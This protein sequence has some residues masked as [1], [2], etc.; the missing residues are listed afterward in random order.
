MKVKFSKKFRKQYEKLDVKIRA[1]FESRLQMFMKDLFD[2]Q[3]NNHQLAANVHLSSPRRRG[4][5]QID[6]RSSRE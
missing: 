5:I 6:S 4:S 2:P 3:L 1:V